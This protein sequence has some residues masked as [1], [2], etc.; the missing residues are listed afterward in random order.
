M[1]QGAQIAI[2]YLHF[3]VTW[4]Y[5]YHLDKNLSMENNA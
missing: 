4:Y 3:T 5:D 2:L 1:I